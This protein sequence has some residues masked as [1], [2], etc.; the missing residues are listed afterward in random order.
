MGVPGGVCV[1]LSSVGGLGG[2]SVVVVV[3]VVAAGGMLIVRQAVIETTK[4]NKS[5][6]DS[7]AF[8]QF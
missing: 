2:V 8:I 1:S 5:R 3:V 6:N 7:K 4:I